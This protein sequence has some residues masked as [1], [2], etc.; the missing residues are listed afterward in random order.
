MEWMSHHEREV[1]GEPDDEDERPLLVFE[2]LP[3]VPRD[4]AFLSEIEQAP[5]GS[6]FMGVNGGVNGVEGLGGDGWAT[7]SSP[8]EEPAISN[9]EGDE[10]GVSNGV[11]T[12]L[13]LLP[14]LS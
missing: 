9:L 7:S 2:S 13:P 10:S 1:Q 6:F 11:F 3:E 12:P 4:L 8:E 5:A 14:S